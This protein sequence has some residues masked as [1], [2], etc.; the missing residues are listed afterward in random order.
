MTRA[1]ANGARGGEGGLQRRGVI[2]RAR[3]EGRG[4]SERVGERVEGVELKGTQRSASASARVAGAR[5]VRV[6]GMGGV[7]LEGTACLRAAGRRRVVWARLA[8]FMRGIRAA[9][10]RITSCGGRPLIGT[11]R[12]LWRSCTV[13][14]DAL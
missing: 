10:R 2:V 13:T 8:R 1:H 6:V 11:D 3:G 12:A 5:S 7:S 14:V 9:F 4:Q